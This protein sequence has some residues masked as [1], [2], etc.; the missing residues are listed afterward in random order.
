MEYSQQKVDD[1]W[2]PY[3]TSLNPQSKFE[4]GT[5]QQQRHLPYI[6]SFRYGLPVSELQGLKLS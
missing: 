6:A 4:R 5:Y 3:K 1:A 2:T